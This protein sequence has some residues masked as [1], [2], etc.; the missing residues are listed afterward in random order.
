MN[1]RARAAALALAALLALAAADPDNPKA[2][3]GAYCPFP[4]PGEKPAC[5]EPVAQVQGS[6][7]NLADVKK[8]CQFRNFRFYFRSDSRRQDGLPKDITF[9]Y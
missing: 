7:Q 5:F 2:Q 8:Q 3:P 6:I 4:K 9:S 1:T